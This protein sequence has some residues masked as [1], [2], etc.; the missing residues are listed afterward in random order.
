[1][2]EK[3]IKAL[4]EAQAAMLTKLILANSRMQARIYKL[5][6]REQQEKLDAFRQSSE[7]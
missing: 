3:E 7:P 1:M 6:S 4:A 2:G 5:L